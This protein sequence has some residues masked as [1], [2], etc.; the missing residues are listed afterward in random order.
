M[1]RYG[2]IGGFAAAVTVWAS[3]VAA[4]GDPG[5]VEGGAPTAGPVELEVVHDWRTT[6]AAEKLAAALEAHTPYRWVDGEAEEMVLVSRIIGGDPPE[7]ALM[8]LGRRSAE[9]ARTGFLLD[10]TELSVAQDWRGKLADPA[11]LDACTIEGRV[12]CVPVTIRVAGWVMLSR[13]GFA[14]ADVALP[15]DWDRLRAAEE[16]LRA[17]GIPPL[18]LEGP[19]VLADALA[20]FTLAAGGRNAWLAAHRDGDARAVGTPAF[21]RGFEQVGR[22]RELASGAATQTGEGPQATIGPAAL[23]TAGGSWLGPAEGDWK[24]LPGLGTAGPL[25]VT[26]DGFFFPNRGDAALAQAQLA[27]AALLLDPSVQTALSND[28]GVLP[29]R[30]GVALTSLHPCTRRGLVALGAGGSVPARELL[31]PLP[32]EEE[33]DTLLAAFWDDPDMTPADLQERYSEVI[34]QGR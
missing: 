28:L 27:F 2:T 4:Q 31:V 10:L 19:D 7:A 26:G 11:V 14:R 23:I 25:A 15:E 33:L 30:R 17:V 22:M 34:A 8:P 16:P 21:T 20:S 18:E 24:C 12:F 6:A 1:G 32:I 13:P 5:P 3:A 9:L 29:A